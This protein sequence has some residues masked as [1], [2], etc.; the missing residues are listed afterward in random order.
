M[1]CRCLGYPIIQ[2]TCWLVRE[3]A[4]HGMLS[5]VERRKPDFPEGEKIPRE[6]WQFGLLAVS[7]TGQ[8]AELLGQILPKA[9]RG[10][11]R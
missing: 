11:L 2:G 5:W 4:M 9:E 8:E 7:S 6:M 10:K 3:T 1:K